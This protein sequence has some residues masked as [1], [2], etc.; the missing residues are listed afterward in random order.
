[1]EHVFIFFFSESEVGAENIACIQTQLWQQ[2]PHHT[3]MIAE[4]YNTAAQ[5]STNSKSL[6]GS[7]A[8]SLSVRFMTSLGTA[9]PGT[10][11]T[12][13]RKGNMLSLSHD[14]STGGFSQK[15]GRD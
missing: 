14:S 6:L 10:E 7:S 2:N 12:F 1:M 15:D 9:L 11:G 4:L 3:K 5:R 13:L 8:T